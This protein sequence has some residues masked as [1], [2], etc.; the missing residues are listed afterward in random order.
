MD[1]LDQLLIEKL[2]TIAPVYQD[3]VPED[4]FKNELKNKY[5]YFIFETGGMQRAE[6]KQNTLTQNV[7]VRFYGEDVSHIDHVQIDIITLLE[8]VGYTFLNSDKSA[9]QKGQEDAYIDEVEFH[10]L[11]SFK[12]VCQLA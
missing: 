8:S 9:I 6:E 5:Y 3:Y 4:V 10:F 2:T 7:L 1:K 11:R 12:Y